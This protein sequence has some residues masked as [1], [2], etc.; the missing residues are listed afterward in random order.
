MI[1][2]TKFQEVQ[3]G[4]TT[5][6]WEGSTSRW[7]HLSC[8]IHERE[9]AVFLDPLRIGLTSLSPSIE[10]KESLFQGYIATFLGSKNPIASY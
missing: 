1:G 3:R 10:S 5:G 8:W 7:S 9:S 2:T 4:L 6:S